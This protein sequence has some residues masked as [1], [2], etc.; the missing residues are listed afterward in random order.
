MKNTIIETFEKIYNF[1]LSY[2]DFI[3]T[4]QQKIQ[5]LDIVLKQFE[6]L[7][8]IPTVEKENIEL[9]ELGTLPIWDKPEKK[10]TDFS[11]LRIELEETNFG[12]GNNANEFTFSTEGDFT[13][14]Y[15]DDDFATAMHEGFGT[16]SEGCV[17]FFETK[18]DSVAIQDARMLFNSGNLVG[19]IDS[20]EVYT[21]KYGENLSVL[22]MLARFRIL[23]K[24]KIEAKKIVEKILGIMLT[25]VGFIT[26][27]EREEYDIVMKEYEKLL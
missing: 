25:K 8:D 10:F 7:N 14:K 16:T 19:A 13:E 21:N 5:K 26:K 1:F 9:S 4:N 27:M 2:K 15:D 6:K 17:E 24:D 12:F 20:L 22:I 3:W 18:K 23:T 11:Q